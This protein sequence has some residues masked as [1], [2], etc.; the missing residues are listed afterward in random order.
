MVVG[1]WRVVVG[2]LW[3]WEVGG[4]GWVV[5]GGCVSRL[6]FFPLYAS[7]PVMHG[8]QMLMDYDEWR[9]APAPE[10]ETKVKND[11]MLIIGL[12]GHATEAEMDKAYQHGMHFFCPKPCTTDMLGAILALRRKNPTLDMC[13]SALAGTSEPA[14]QGGYKNSGKYGGNSG[15]YSDAG[16]SSAKS[17]RAKLLSRPQQKT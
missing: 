9:A 5:C 16:G 14:E 2:E 17:P 15:K 13:L 4:G 1:G 11:E 12:S 6:S 10:G 7:Q 3:W 8:V